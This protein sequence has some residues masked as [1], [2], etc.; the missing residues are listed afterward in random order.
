MGT[1]STPNSAAA[2]TPTA[3]PS[4]SAPTNTNQVRPG[5]APARVYMNEKIVP[6]LLEGMK[7]IAKEQP[8]NPLRALGEFLI[9]KS[10][11]VEGRPPSSADQ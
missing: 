8:A 3:E 2:N 9:Q 5:G 1:A 10:N 6:Y 11:D 4:G 7:G